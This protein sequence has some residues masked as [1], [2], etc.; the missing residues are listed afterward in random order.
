MSGSGWNTIDSDAGVFSEL[1]ERL[2]VKDVEINDLYSIDS[3]SLKQLDPVY[4][5][6]FLFKYGKIDHQY[7]LDGN[8]PIE[9]E[10]D[11]DYPI[12]DMFFANQTVQNSCATQAVLNIL[13][14]KDKE[15]DIGDDLRNFKSFVN[16]FDGYMVGDTILNSDII[17]TIHNSFSPPQ[18][19]IDTDKPRRHHN[20][21]N[22]DDGIFH[23][24][25]YIH[26][27]GYIYEL[28][29]LKNCPIRHVECQSN[30]EFYEKLPGVIQKRISHFGNELRFSLLAVTDNKLLRAQ[31]LNQEFEIHTQLMKRE[32]W[33]YE[34]ELRR[35]DY[36]GLVM[37]LLINISK[38]KNDD[39]W[40]KM[41][42]SAR[43][44]TIQR[45]DAGEYN[46]RSHY[47]D[48]D[49]SDEYNI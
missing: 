49:T 15:I 45:V 41:L 46:E 47:L 12:R 42:V 8:K 33:K 13:L 5:V 32:T 14:N 20:Y 38:E 2:N 35:Q 22:Q 43:E 24:V 25:G 34:N 6:I 23:F 4:G 26:N 1:V 40:E 7:A 18:S 10:Y 39:E 21:T 17:R 31:R 37:R 3:D 30:E 36:T 48:A 29:G 11:Y 9:G 44:K 28:D 27:N 19:L 16:G